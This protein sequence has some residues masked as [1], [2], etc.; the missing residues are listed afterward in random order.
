MASLVVGGDDVQRE[1]A[2]NSLDQ[3]L[4]ILHVGD[5]RSL[6]VNSHTT[7]TVTLRHV[8]GRATET[9]VGRQVDVQIDEVVGQV[10]GERVLRLHLLLLV[11]RKMLKVLDRHA[12]LLKEISGTSSGEQVVIKIVELLDRG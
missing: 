12:V 11:V 10:L 3:D 5:Q 8:V 4:R 2:S 1:V 7:S 9:V 6:V